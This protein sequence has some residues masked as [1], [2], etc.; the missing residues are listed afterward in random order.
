MTSEA[1]EIT[2]MIDSR[3]F[4]EPQ[5]GE[6]S[7]APLIAAAKAGDSEAFERLIVFFHRKVL[8]TA[9]RLLGNEED[10]RD[11]AQEAFLR[12]FKYRRTFK[13]DQDFSGWLYRI[14]VNACRDLARKDRHREHTTSID[15]LTEGSSIESIPSEDDQEAAAIRSQNMAMI[16]QA[17]NTLSDKERAALVLRDLEGLSTE[18]VARILGSSQATVRSQISSA[19]T[20]IKLYHERITRRGWRS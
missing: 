5:P 12:A 19:R 16:S 2:L 17:L 13:S 6:S 9:W 18:E 1:A 3:D 10:A 8:T 4:R 20:K 7:Y 15:A 14:V 11:A